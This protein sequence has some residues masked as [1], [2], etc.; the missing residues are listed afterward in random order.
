MKII[1]DE[2]FI[3]NLEDLMLNQIDTH[4]EIFYSALRD[5]YNKSDEDFIETINKEC[6]G[7]SKIVDFQGFCRTFY[8]AYKEMVEKTGI[9]NLIEEHKDNAIS[10]SDYDIY[11][12][13]FYNVYKRTDLA[14]L[15]TKLGVFDFYTKEERYQAIL[16][17]CNN[18]N[19]KLN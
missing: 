2:I 18:N 7:I 5:L 1:D 17:F 12:E 11:V 15:R 9:T 4:K 14:T 19:I 16:E 3:K 8:F 6:Q 10:Y 13:L